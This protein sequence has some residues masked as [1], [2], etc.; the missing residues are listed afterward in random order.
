MVLNRFMSNGYLGN[1]YMSWVQ[2]PEPTNHIYKHGCHVLFDT[3]R[4]EGDLFV[5]LCSFLA[6]GRICWLK[7]WEEWKSCLCDGFTKDGFTKDW[8]WCCYSTIWV[9]CSKC[10]KTDTQ[11]LADSDWWNDSLWEKQLG[12]KRWE[13][14]CYLSLQ[15]CRQHL[16]LYIHNPTS[17]QPL[18]CDLG[19][20]RSRKK[21]MSF[22]NHFQVCLSCLELC[23]LLISLKLLN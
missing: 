2:I 5:N 20:W 12:W 4:S 17:H 10:E 8:Q 13:Q 7:L 18:P 3:P 15:R 21:P 23:L 16:K 9:E 6:F 19:F 14:P 1:G 22:I 11:S